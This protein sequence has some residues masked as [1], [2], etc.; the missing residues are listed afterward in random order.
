MLLQ[1]SLCNNIHMISFT[2]IFLHL[3]FSILCSPATTV[4]AITHSGMFQ[5]QSRN[6]VD[7]WLTGDC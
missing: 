2:K 1:F 6:G 4:L 5:V 7:E 3:N